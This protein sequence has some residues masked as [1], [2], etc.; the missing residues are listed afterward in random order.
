MTANVT[1]EGTNVEKSVKKTLMIVN[2]VMRI[3]QT[4]GSYSTNGL[5]FRG[6]F[7]TFA[8][9]KDD[10]LPGIRLSVCAS[11]FFSMEDLSN[12]HYE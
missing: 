2:H 9:D 1:E 4:K 7:Q 11:L 10:P 8:P 3:E 6:T 5:P 12:I